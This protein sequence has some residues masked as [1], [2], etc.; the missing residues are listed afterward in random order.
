MRRADALDDLFAA[1]FLQI[2]SRLPGTI[3]GAA[4]GAGCADLL[5][6]RRSGE[7]VG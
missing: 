1:K 7:A 3:G 2:I 6:K 5:G 4:P